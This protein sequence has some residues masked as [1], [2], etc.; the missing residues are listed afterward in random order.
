ML[1]CMTINKLHPLNTKGRPTKA[2]ARPLS[3]NTRL[4]QLCTCM[5]IHYLISDLKKL[6]LQGAHHMIQ[7][8]L[9]VCIL[10]ESSAL[11]TVGAFFRCC[12]QIVDDL[13]QIPTIQNKKGQPLM[14]HLFSS[15][16]GWSLLSSS[17]CSWNEDG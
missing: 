13:P 14:I 6:I 3:A 15:T 2:C 8:H 12:G 9:A 4:H 1:A 16:F 11:L 17:S 7:L 5:C 10:G